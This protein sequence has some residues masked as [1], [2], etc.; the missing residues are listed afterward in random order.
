MALQKGALLEAE[1]F[2]GKALSSLTGA[3]RCAPAAGADLRP[4]RKARKALETLEPMLDAQEPDAQTLSMAAA[5]YSER[6]CEKAEELLRAPSS[7][8]RRTPQPD[9]A[10]ADTALSPTTRARVR[11]S[12]SRSPM[13][14]PGPMRTWR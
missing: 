11:Q 1:Q 9:G 13:R 6:R 8:T 12:W 5:A 10:G 7:S 4:V 2:L 14:T 3:C